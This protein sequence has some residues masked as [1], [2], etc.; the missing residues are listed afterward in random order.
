MHKHSNN[1]TDIIHTLSGAMSSKGATK[2]QYLSTIAIKALC[3]HLYNGTDG[4]GGAIKYGKDNWQKG[5]HDSSFILDRLNHGID[6]AVILATV[7]QDYMNAPEKYNQ[8]EMDKHIRGMGAN[9]MFV[10]HAI[11]RI[12]AL[13]NKKESK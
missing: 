6:H 8:V 13:N 3:E 5:T 9:W 10:Q 7:L 2:N 12:K 11:E 4:T 1:E